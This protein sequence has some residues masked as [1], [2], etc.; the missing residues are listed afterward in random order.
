MGWLIGYA[1]IGAVLWGIAKALYEKLE[2]DV[3]GDD[4]KF[5]L[6]FFAILWPAFLGFVVCVYLPGKATYRVARDWFGRHAH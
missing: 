2:G 4:W 1:V 6:G 3:L 5:M